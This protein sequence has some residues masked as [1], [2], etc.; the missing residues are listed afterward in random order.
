MSARNKIISRGWTSEAAD[1]ML[2][3]ANA[4]ADPVAFGIVGQILSRAQRSAYRKKPIPN[5]LR[6]QVFAR[7]GFKCKVC[8]STQDLCIDHI[9]PER[10]GGATTLKNLQVL[11]RSCNSRKKDHE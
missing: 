1:M 10:R 7:D 3:R 4:D 2:K 5:S 9:I 8:G 6:T 11:C